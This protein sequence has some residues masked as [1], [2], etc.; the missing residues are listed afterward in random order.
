M[1]V[2]LGFLD[3]EIDSKTKS[4][5]IRLTEDGEKLLKFLQ[6]VKDLTT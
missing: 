5:G 3:H 6:G 2:D 4:D 1:L